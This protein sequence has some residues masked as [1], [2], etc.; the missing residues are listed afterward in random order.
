MKRSAR[1]CPLRSA[2]TQ[3]RLRVRSFVA[4][5]APVVTPRIR[6]LRSSAPRPIRYVLVLA[7]AMLALAAA[8]CGGDDDG[9]ESLPSL[10]VVT[11]NMANAVDL[12]GVSCVS[13]DRSTAPNRRALLPGD[14][15]GRLQRARRRDC[16]SGRRKLNTSAT[17]RLIS[18]V[19]S[20]VPFA[21]SA[22]KSA[23]AYGK[24]CV[25]MAAR[26]MRGTHPPSWARGRQAGS[27]RSI[28]SIGRVPRFR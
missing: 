21:I 15:A 28:G 12:S 25:V 17:R 3:G 5:T 2:A 19:R 1:G 23:S 9:R 13:V 24:G 22:L 18:P 16:A 20:P 8:S 10:T 4:A 26:V 6:S 14:R 7:A 27:G 11:V